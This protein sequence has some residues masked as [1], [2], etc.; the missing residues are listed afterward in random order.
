MSHLHNHEIIYKDTLKWYIIQNF[1]GKYNT[2]KGKEL[3]FK[4]DV[5]IHCMF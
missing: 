1:H 2:V 4:H 5:I 3:V